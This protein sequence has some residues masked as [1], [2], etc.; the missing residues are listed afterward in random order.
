MS[1][2]DALAK[3]TC[4]PADLLDLQAWRLQAGGRAD[5]TLF[6][7]G[8]GWQVHADDLTSKAKN[9]PFDGRPVQGMVLR[10]VIDGR[11]VYRVDV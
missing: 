5:F 4:A 2:L 10:T 7:P 11:T 8:R 6:D 9:T 3:V 1:L